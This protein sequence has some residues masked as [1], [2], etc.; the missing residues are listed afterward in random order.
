MFILTRADWLENCIDNIYRVQAT[1]MEEQ[2]SDA[3]YQRY[4]RIYKLQYQYK[5]FT[6]I[7]PEFRNAASGAEPIVMLPDFLV[8]K[9]PYPIYVYLYAI[10]LYSTNPDMGQREVA[11]ATRE[12]FGLESFAH[13]TLGRALK[14][15]VHNVQAVEKPTE[16]YP[17]DAPGSDRGED[18]CQDANAARAARE[19]E[20]EEDSQPD[21]QPS[22]PTTRL[23][24]ALR[25]H[26][27]KILGGKASQGIRQAITYCLELAGTWFKEYHRLLL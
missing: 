24:Y 9:R 27:A 13:T 16:A 8:P 14:A 22:F 25:K 5:E 12:R 7:C 23:T 19:E 18:E 11:E 1:D 2:Y 6:I 15:F 17:S 21:S 10:D 4:E 26:V 3:G 20:E